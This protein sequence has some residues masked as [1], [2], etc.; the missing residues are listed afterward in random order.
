MAPTNAARAA[1]VC[2]RVLRA[3]RTAFLFTDLD[4]SLSLACLPRHL[5][6]RPLRRVSGRAL[7]SG[8][9]RA[10]RRV[11]H[12]R[13]VVGRA[14]ALLVVPR[15]LVK[16]GYSMTWSA[17]SSSDCGIIRPRALYSSEQFS[18]QKT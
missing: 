12:P 7:S 8:A 2:A 15:E 9:G 11:L 17:R 4:A 18:D 14:P 13:G 5:P 3:Y 10:R 1:Q 6:R 16:H